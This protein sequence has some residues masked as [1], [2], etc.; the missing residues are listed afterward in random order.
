MIKLKLFDIIDLDIAEGIITSGAD[1]VI[2][3]IGS[4]E[5]GNDTLVLS[6]NTHIV[7][8]D[9]NSLREIFKDI[10]F[11]EKRLE[12]ANFYETYVD[13]IYNILVEDLGFNSLMKP[14]YFEPLI[15]FVYD[16][17]YNVRI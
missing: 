6:T 2:E 4:E 1:R 13:E 16:E 14:R 8:I 7:F 9:N 12:W 17:V 15:E 5:V 3:Y 11:E 10:N